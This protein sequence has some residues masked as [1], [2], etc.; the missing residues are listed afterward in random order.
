MS[1][2]KL[3]SIEVL[4]KELRLKVQKEANEKIK[5]DT[6]ALSELAEE[7]V[8]PCVLVR[9]APKLT[10]LFNVEAVFAALV[11]RS[12]T[13]NDTATIIREVVDQR[14][15]WRKQWEEKAK[16]ETAEKAEGLANEE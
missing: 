4:A 5:I 12:K 1:A 7:G 11:A 9:R 6:F 8:L 14:I 16:E 15:F 13:T 3:V 10:L 2:E